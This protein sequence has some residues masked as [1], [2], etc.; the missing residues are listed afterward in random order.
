MKRG[1]E[2][3]RGSR[4]N[5]FQ[6]ERKRETSGLN[7]GEEKKIVLIQENRRRLESFHFS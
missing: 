2:K 6:D 5:M 4:R 7:T 1:E 3:R